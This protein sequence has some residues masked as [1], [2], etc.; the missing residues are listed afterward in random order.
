MAVLAVARMGNPVL[1]EV[2]DPVDPELLA[3]ASFQ[4]FCDDLLESMEE[5]DGAGLAAPQVFHSLRVVVFQLS[6][7]QG[8]IFLVNPVITAISEARAWGYEGCLSVPELRGR[9]ERWVDIRVDAIDRE[10]RPFAFEAHGYA[11][12]VVQHECDHLDGV[13]YVDRADPKSL[14]FLREFRRYGPPVGGDEDETDGDEDPGDADA[15]DDDAGDE[16]SG[17]EITGD[18]DRDDRHREDAEAG[19]DDRDER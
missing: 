10:G 6:E 9:V 1:R 13:L 18:D 16:E 4:D 14:C 2:A 7:E 17:E 19:G 3:S 8:P 11:A 12:R 5:H 15:G